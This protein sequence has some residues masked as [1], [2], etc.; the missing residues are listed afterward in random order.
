[1]KHVDEK[2]IPVILADKIHNLS[3][4]YQDYLVVG[5]RIWDRFNRGKDQQQW[6]YESLVQ[7]MKERGV[8]GSLF[9]EFAELVKK[10]FS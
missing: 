1:M 10:M 9:D 2:A 4:S 5:D 6:Y 7:A 3:S 8:Q